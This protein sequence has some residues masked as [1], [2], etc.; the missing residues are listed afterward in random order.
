MVILLSQN[1]SSEVLFEEQELL[2]VSKEQADSVPFRNLTRNF[3][4]SSTWNLTTGWA[5]ISKGKYRRHW[6]QTQVHAP[7]PQWIYLSIN[8][9]FSK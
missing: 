9:L 1:D 3:E 8:W 5:Q 6:I 7:V 2:Y 4:F